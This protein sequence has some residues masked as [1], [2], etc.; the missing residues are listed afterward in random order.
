[1]IQKLFFFVTVSAPEVEVIVLNSTAIEINWRNTKIAGHLI[2]FDGY[3][4][5]YQRSGQKMLT[6][7][8]TQNTTTFTLMNLGKIISFIYIKK[9]HPSQNCYVKSCIPRFRVTGKEVNV[10]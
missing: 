4:I 1:M 5:N 2:K 3:K 6:V 10:K 7:I 9:S 8:V